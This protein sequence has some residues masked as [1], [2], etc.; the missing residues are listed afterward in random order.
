M[1]RRRTRA[2][3]D[4]RARSRRQGRQP[5]D[6]GAERSHEPAPSAPS[7]TTTSGGRQES[8]I[9]RFLAGANTA[10]AGLAKLRLHELGNRLHGQRD[11]DP[12]RFAQ[13]LARRGVRCEHGR[14][15]VRRQDRPLD[16]A[17]E[18]R[19]LLRMIQ[20]APYCRSD[21]RDHDYSALAHGSCFQMLSVGRSRLYE[22]APRYRLHGA[23][24]PNR[25]SNRDRRHHPARVPRPPAVRGCSPLC[26]S[27]RA[28]PARVHAPPPR[29]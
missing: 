5:G 24:R 16:V 3:L 25:R 18:L 26:P 27:V 13:R 29:A 19:Y 1:R 2:S 9:S 6:T 28:S 14:Q 21:D 7:V 12:P 4:G 23:L 15:A 8:R 20:A 11:G 10:A 22:G 17:T